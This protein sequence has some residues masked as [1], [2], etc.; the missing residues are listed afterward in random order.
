M[1]R[2][3]LGTFKKIVRPFLPKPV[4]RAYRSF[5]RT[6]VLPLQFWSV[7]R[8]D[9]R[10]LAK[11]VLVQLP[12]AAIRNRVHG[13]PD[14]NTYLQVG[15][16]CT[17]DVEAALQS[18]GRSLGSFSHCLDFGCGCGRTLQSL[19]P[20]APQAKVFGT[21]IDSAAISWCRKNFR[22]STFGVNRPLPPLDYETGFF[23]LI[24][25]ISVFTHLDEHY[26]FKWLEELKRIAAP[27]GILLLSLQGDSY[28]KNL[29]SSVVD[30]IK[31]KGFVFHKTDYWKGL[32]PEWYQ[33]S[34]HTPAYVQ[35]VYS[36]YFKVL[37]Y[38]PRGLNHSHDL[39]VLQRAA[40][41]GP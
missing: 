20:R 18:M 11:Q 27:N 39:V 36:R 12:P 22:G 4:L 23:D 26:Q 38:I 29:P 24:L 19:I 9:R 32:F 28:W 13:T 2:E 15:L 35:N 7:D 17:Q 40:G 16:N 25:A 30:E 33:L 14:A 21:D 6:I 5:R 34:Y 3:L 37:N 1:A 10:T 31:A 41:S 8:Q